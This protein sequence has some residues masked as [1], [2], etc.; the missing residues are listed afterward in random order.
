MSRGITQYYH[1]C[2]RINYEI[3]QRHSAL[4]AFEQSGQLYVN[5]QR[6]VAEANAARGHDGLDGIIMQV[7]SELALPEM[8]G[9]P[10]IDM[11]VQL[12]LIIEPRLHE[13]VSRTVQRLA[14]YFPIS[15]KRFRRALLDAERDLNQKQGMSGGNVYVFSFNLD[16]EPLSPIGSM[17]CSGGCSMEGHAIPLV[18]YRTSSNAVEIPLTYFVRRGSAYERQESAIPALS[19]R[20]FVDV[21]QYHF[22]TRFFSGR[23]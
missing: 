22:H 14:G 1:A 21:A 5:L 15:G 19:I 7:A 16:G 6:S 17:P 23:G 18:G 12:R 3:W 2:G 10:Q 9:M 4:P 8:T 11:A 13:G 20:D